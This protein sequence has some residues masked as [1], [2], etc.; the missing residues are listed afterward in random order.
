MWQWFKAQNATVKGMV[1]FGLLMI[2]GIIVR[3]SAISGEIADAFSRLFSQPQQ[4]QV[5]QAAQPT[6][7]GTTDESIDY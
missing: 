6:T 5:E 1:I 3:W 4:E 7:N 2:I